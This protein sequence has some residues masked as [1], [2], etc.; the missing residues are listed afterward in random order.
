MLPLLSVVLSIFSTDNG[1]VAHL[2]RT[3][4][5][6]YLANTVLLVGGVGIGVAV[7]GTG[8]AWLVAM[9]EFP[10][11]RYF[12][13]ALII[14]LALPA[15]ILAYAYTDLLSHPGLV[16][17]ALREVTGW[18]PRDY[19]FPNVR[20]LGGATV[21]FTL[22]LYPYVYL[23]ARSAFLEQSMCY[24]EVSRTLGRSPLES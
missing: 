21:M 3:V 18:G 9:C 16:Q 8:T 20:S 13:W 19:W 24:T 11:R 12:E 4:L 14:P 5:P 6:D 22:V 10:G 1:T 2:S 17:S 23:L 15:Y 7:I